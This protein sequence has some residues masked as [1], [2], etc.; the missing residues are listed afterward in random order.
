MGSQAALRALSPGRVIVVS[1][2]VHQ[3]SIG[4]ILQQAS[5]QHKTSLSKDPLDKLFTILV[6]V[7]NDRQNCDTVEEMKLSA[8]DKITDPFIS[9]KL[10]VLDGGFT[11]KVE[12][13][14]ASDIAFIAAK[15][16]NINPSKII[17]DHKKRQIPRFRYAFNRI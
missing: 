14:R 10:A 11:Q 4:I 13:I 8:D 12:E 17:D 3:N 1:N 15:Q 5:L 16:I 2:K 6:A 9:R 7:G